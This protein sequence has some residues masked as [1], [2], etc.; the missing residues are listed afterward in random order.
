MQVS[1][2]KHSEF[3]AALGKILK[4]KIHVAP[5][6]AQGLKRVAKVKQTTE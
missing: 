6:T 3:H 4:T 2:T 1:A 5:V